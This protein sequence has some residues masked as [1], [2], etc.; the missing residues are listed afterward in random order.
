M[1]PP[2]EGSWGLPPEI[3]NTLPGYGL[4]VQKNRTTARQLMEGLGYGPDRRLKVK[5]ATRN[6][7]DFRDTSVIAIDQLKEVYI[8]AELELIETANWFARLA[9]KEYNIGFIFSL[10]TVDDPDQQLY[11]NYICGAERNYM[12][13]CNR[14]LE[15][16]FEQQSVEADPEKRKRLVW[17]IDRKLQEDVA[18]PIIAHTR[19]GTCWQPS[20][21]GLTI[22]RNS[23]Y[24]G[25][26]F[27][28]V[29]LDR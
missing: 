9:R 2:P 15:K 5:F 14:E 6:L 16:Q 3:L 10:S 21:R 13:Y 26:R 8:D 24:N 11:E 1:L 27:E 20:V 4:D 25:W 17:E 7:P 28:D 29:W 12:G 22:M 23:L 19:L 18:R